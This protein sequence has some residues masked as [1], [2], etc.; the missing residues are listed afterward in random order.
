MAGPEGVY[1]AGDIADLPDNRANY[2]I[3]A[4]YAAKVIEKPVIETATAPP[5]EDTAATPVIAKMKVPEL[6]EFAAI[7]DI[8]ISGARRKDEIIAII[9]PAGKDKTDQE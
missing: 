8:D 9:E 5:P 6:R 2:L 7:N 4:G 3:S 1:Q